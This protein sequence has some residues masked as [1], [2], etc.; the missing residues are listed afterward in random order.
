[1]ESYEFIYLPFKANATNVSWSVVDKNNTKLTWANI[2]NQG[3]FSTQNKNYIFNYEDKTGIANK[4]TKL[5]VNATYNDGNITHSV[6][7][8]IELNFKS[9]CIPFDR[10]EYSE[11]ESIWDNNKNYNR[12]LE[13][14]ITCKTIY[15]F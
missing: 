2:N 15:N 7:V 6:F 9:T 5:K 11:T 13:N 1:M 14:P 12:K 8:D 4:I 3:I 10:Y